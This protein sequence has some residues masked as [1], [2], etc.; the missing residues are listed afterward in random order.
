M[1]P[2]TKPLE[3]AA[4]DFQ[5][6]IIDDIEKEYRRRLESKNSYKPETGGKEKPKKSDNFFI[7]EAEEAEDE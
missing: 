3:Q 1:F 5:Q 4:I 6:K 2:S 7:E